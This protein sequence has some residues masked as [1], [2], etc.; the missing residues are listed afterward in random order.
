MNPKDLIRH[1]LIGLDVEVVKAKNH[2]LEGIKGKIIDETKNTL[3]IK[4]KD[5]MKKILK[6]QATFNL[7]VA[8]TFSLRRRWIS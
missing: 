1:E 6:A 7:K 3:I 5:K 4:Q 2:S 8:G